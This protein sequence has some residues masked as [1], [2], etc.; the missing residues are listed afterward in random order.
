MFSRVLMQMICLLLLTAG[1]IG[2]L[3]AGF[4]TAAIV[5][6]YFQEGRLLAGDQRM[7]AGGVKWLLIAAFLIGSGVWLRRKIF[8]HARDKS[9][10]LVQ[11][12]FGQSERI[13]QYTTEV[14]FFVWLATQL[15]ALIVG[16]GATKIL[17]IA[18][19]LVIA[20]LCKHL[21]IAI[22]EISHL[23]AACLLGFER[24]K[25]QVGTG[26]LLWSRSFPSGLTCEWRFWS[27]GYVI[28]TPKNIEGFRARYFLFVGAGPLA[29]VTVLWSFYQL[30]VHFFGGLPIAFGH[31]PAGLT[32]SALFC[33]IALLALGGILPHQ[34]WVGPR[35]VW[36]DGYWLIRLL[37]GSKKQI[38]ELA[39]R[40]NWRE[41]LK[42]LGSDGSQSLTAAASR[43]QELCVTIV[44]P[45]GFHEQRERLKTQLIPLHPTSSPLA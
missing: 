32:A 2:T 39:G 33:W 13:V 4:A 45:M 26:L 7:L 15:W 8:G 34:V 1:T 37:T 11:S 31:S 24:R 14:L 3:A 41:L 5:V 35:L 44:N 18:G 12:K 19:W 42:L 16:K 20:F 28:A 10:R 23:T 27:G 9:F 22:H 36:N 43:G 29:D 25:I 38:A 6:V 17:D 21:H 30:I 40:S